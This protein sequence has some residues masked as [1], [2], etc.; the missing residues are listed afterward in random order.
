MDATAASTGEASRT[1]ANRS[2]RD[3]ARLREQ[4][5]AA[6]DD[7]ARINEDVAQS[8]RAARIREVREH[9][10]TQRFTLLV[11]GEF[12]RGKS[13][14][15]N[16]LLGA[17]AL[18]VGAAPT[19]A[20]LTRVT[21]GDEPSARIVLDD[22][23]ARDVDP[24]RLADEI[25]LVQ[26]GEGANQARH[27]G[28]ARAEVALP[29]AICRHGVDIVDSPGLGEHRTRTEVTYE[30]L[31]AADAV[32]FVSDAAQL[33]NED[34]EFVRTRLAS[35]EIDNVF[36]VINKWD[37][38][39][40][41]SE[42][43]EAE[44]TA[45][46]RRAWSLFVPEPKVGYNGQDLRANRIYPLSCRPNLAPEEERA[47]LD[48]LFAAFRED[49]EAFLV[50]EAGRVALDRALARARA[51]LA[52]TQSG[53]RARLPV[54]EADLAEFERRVTAAEMEL[55][56]LETPRQAIRNAI[57]ARRQ[58]I[59][60][61]VRR[62]ATEGLPEVEAR[63]TTDYAQWEYRPKQA[64]TQR[65]LDGMQDSFRRQKIREELRARAHEIAVAQLEPW[66]N[67][68]SSYVE[69]QVRELLQEVTPEVGA[70]DAT[71]EQA[72]RILAGLDAEADTSEKDKE[73][74]LKRG[75]AAGIG[76]LLLD[77]FL[78]M[79]GGMHGFKGLGRTLLYQFA[80]MV[81]VAL[82]GLPALPVLVASSVIATVQNSEDLIQGLKDQALDEVLERIRAMRTTG[83]GDLE[84]QATTSLEACSAA[85]EKAVE[86]RID[87][88]REQVEALRAQVGSVRAEH[89]Q[90]RTRLSEA[91]DAVAAIAERLEAVA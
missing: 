84:A 87:D 20:V 50:R 66:A 19:T 41:E 28:I 13:T 27:A 60:Q 11:L 72:M 80:G 1:D 88:H 63:I 9:L 29:V 49:L 46:R 74:M 16:R 48:A 47:G 89:D 44:I 53:L 91:Q 56:K 68:L 31:P 5:V 52:E 38:V 36:F 76:A 33:G 25:T 22:G 6:L 12:K 2:L 64:I 78:I 75:A 86:G 59:R 70:I 43:P 85:I 55:R 54:L 17:D 42:D 37:R 39:Y 57:A 90:E 69:T 58:T 4:I 79:S 67:G 45:L 7:L 35:E 23:S 15:I 40:N 71:F 62:R 34:E 77:P 10:M 73:D 61:E 18:P 51:L 82:V 3:Y 30:A 81:V 8:A 24:T 14:L 21:F 65:V 83:L 26:T 32:V